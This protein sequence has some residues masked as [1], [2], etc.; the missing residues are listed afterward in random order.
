MLNNIVLIGFMGSGKTTIGREVARLKQSILLDTDSIIEANAGMSVNE[1]FRRSG[2]AHFRE[3]EISLCEFLRKNV[4]NAIIATGGG[5]P[6]NYDV[7]ELGSVFYLKAP[8][9]ALAGR[10]TADK[11]HKR[12]LFRRFDLAAE[13]YERRILHYEK[14]ADFTLNALDSITQIAERICNANL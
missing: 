10:I 1:I 6:V 8:I 13:L 3:M 14:Q 2:E 11:S 5:I 4:K 7:R 9:E 12:P